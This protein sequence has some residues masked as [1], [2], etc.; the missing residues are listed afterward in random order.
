MGRILVDHVLVQVERLGADRA[1]IRVISTQVELK[2]WYRGISFIEG[3]TK[4]F[5]RLPF[6]VTFMSCEIK[7]EG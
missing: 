3:E 6:Q 1:G 7:G 4:R 2:E 5:A